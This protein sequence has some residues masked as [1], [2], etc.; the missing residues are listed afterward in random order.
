MSQPNTNPG[1]LDGVRVI[2][3]T[4]VV[5]GPLATRMLAD[6][7]ADVVRIE[8]PG[9]DVIRSY[10]PMR[11]EGMSAF[12]MNLNRNKR[13]V[14]LDLKSEAG[15]KAVMDLVAT[16][17]V[18]VSNMRRSA[19]DRLG[20]DEASV[21]AVRPDIIY[22]IANGYGSDGPNADHAAYDDIMQAAS[23]LASTFK[24]TLGEPQLVPS[25]YAD[26][27][28]GAHIAFA[29]AAALHGRRA[30]GE[31][32]SIEVPMAETMA[33]FNLVEHLGGQTFEPSFGGFSYSRIKTANR[34]PRRSLDGWVV[35]LPYSRANWEAFWTYG[36]RPDLLDDPRFAGGADRVENADALYGLAGEIIATR[37]TDDWLEFCASNSI[38]AA[39]V[40]DLEHI[41]EDEHF[42]AVGLIQD[43]VHPTEGDYH[44]VRDPI[45][46]DGRH[47]PLRIPAPRLGADTEAVMSELG[48]TPEAIGEL[49]R[50]AGK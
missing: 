4:N 1:P 34:K 28:T 43:G 19:L 27:V 44:W 31:G 15:H 45:M 21:R 5:M 23:G 20:L 49:E 29:I 14:V 2:D 41:G 13:S 26:K 36:G 39:K 37:T 42:N 10:P 32:T 9:G 40:I 30:T 35:V 38:P 22:C 50:E 8:E 24:W 12:S 11:S 46:F 47:S 6:M 48:W 16:G 3:L 17:D 18:F 7:G 33:A 25:I